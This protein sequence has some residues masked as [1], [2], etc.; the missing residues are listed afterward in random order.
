MRELVTNTKAIIEDMWQ[1]PSL[2]SLVELQE[3]LT[4]AAAVLADIAPRHKP[5]NREETF[6]IVKEAS[7]SLPADA[8]HTQR[9]RDVDPMS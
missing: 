6:V 3:V 5:D 4:D 2:Q 8:K 9:K 7:E 1:H